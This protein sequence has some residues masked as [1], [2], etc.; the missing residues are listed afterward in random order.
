MKKNSYNM[1][2][3]KKIVREALHD[4][5]V[6]EIARKHGLIPRTVR[7]WVKQYGVKGDLWERTENDAK[8]VSLSE[9]DVSHKT[10][11]ELREQIYQLKKQ[12]KKQK[13]EDQLRINILEDLVKKA[14]SLPPESD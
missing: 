12:L 6:S 4:G 1:E 7:S 11:L 14:E 2:L 9:Q 8:K 13:E 5:N 10:V 3:K